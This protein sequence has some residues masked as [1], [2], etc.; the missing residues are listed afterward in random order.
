M[1]VNKIAVTARVICPPKN[2]SEYNVTDDVFGGQINMM[3]DNA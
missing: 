1:I 2:R 3:Q